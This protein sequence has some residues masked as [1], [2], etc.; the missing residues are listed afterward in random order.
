MLFNRPNSGVR[1]KTP[2]LEVRI[3]PIC[4][5]SRNIASLHLLQSVTKLR[6]NMRKIVV[7]IV[8]DLT[9]SK[10]LRRVVA[11]ERKIRKSLGVGPN[12]LL[13]ES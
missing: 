3:A 8:R 10:D 1:V 11:L 13:R 12:D 6:V 9:S 2:I 4:D 5:R 7:D